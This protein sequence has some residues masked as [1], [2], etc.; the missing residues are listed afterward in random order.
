VGVQEARW[1][2]GDTVRAWDFNSLYG[3]ENEN[4]QL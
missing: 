3:K 1:D 2:K 4:H